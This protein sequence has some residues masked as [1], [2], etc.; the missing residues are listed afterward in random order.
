MT[1][2]RDEVFPGPVVHSIETDAMT[3]SN[4]WI[5]NLWN[6]I[7]WCILSMPT[8]DMHLY[9]R[10]SFFQQVETLCANKNHKYVL[11]R[12][13][14]DSAKPKHSLEKQI[15]V[16]CLSP[17]IYIYFFFW[18]YW[19]WGIPM[20]DKGRQ[21]VHPVRHERECTWGP[22]FKPQGHHLEHL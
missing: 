18:V 1:I 14:E 16:L 6:I 9:Y 3:L 15:L 20:G 11:K 5:L 17:Y 22:C 10:C 8:L 21:V 13:H 19:R 12:T 7:C 4:I 2:M